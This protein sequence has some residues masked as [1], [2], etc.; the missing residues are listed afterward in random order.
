MER[1]PATH[2]VIQVE[3]EIPPLAL[4]AQP[5]GGRGGE[6]HGDL[7][8]T[9]GDLGNLGNLGSAG[10]AWAVAPV[11]SMQAR[12]EAC[13]DAGDDVV[14]FCCELPIPLEGQGRVYR[15]SVYKAHTAANGSG[16]TW[17]SAPHPTEEELLAVRASVGSETPESATPPDWAVA[18]RRGRSRCIPGVRV[19]HVALSPDGDVA[20]VWVEDAGGESPDA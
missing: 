16:V 8:V 1:Q 6:Q 18:G 4:L 14:R 17:N 11:V 20:R 15:L 2:K 12:G 7:E 10:D 9:L 19:V 5:A 3:V 13:A